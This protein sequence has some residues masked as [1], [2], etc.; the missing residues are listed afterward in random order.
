MLQ[1]AHRL[2]IFMAAHGYAERLKAI[3]NDSE[4]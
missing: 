4:L 3:L 1:E 2:F